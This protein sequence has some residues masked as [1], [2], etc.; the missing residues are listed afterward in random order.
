M[1]ARQ[2]SCIGAAADLWSMPPLS[3]LRRSSALIA[4]SA[5]LALAA[6]GVAAADQTNC[7][8]RDI[9]PTTSNVAAVQHS[10][11]CLLNEQRVGHGLRRLRANET[12]E[13]VAT[14]Y[15]RRMVRDSFFDH[16]APGGSTMLGRVRATNYLRGTGSWSL[17]ENLAWGTGSLATPA[18]TV[19]AWMNS[20]GHR[21]NILDR[22][23][24][25]IGVGIT[26]GAPVEVSAAQAAAT[27]ATE[28][29]ARS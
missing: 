14:A 5:G 13:R 29:G 25:E 27:Y 16:V 3:I 18:R 10:T 28:F 26:L 19:D 11:L 24:K 7:G 9:Q 12:L 8:G 22:S 1:F 21:R 17:G 4:V 2:R 15:T 20:A 6:P 23:F